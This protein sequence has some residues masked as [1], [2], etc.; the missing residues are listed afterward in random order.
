MYAALS[1]LSYL[2]YL[3]E[4]RGGQ[5]ALKSSFGVATQVTKGGDQRSWGREVLTM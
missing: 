4:Q 3:E 5:D 2:W 1:N